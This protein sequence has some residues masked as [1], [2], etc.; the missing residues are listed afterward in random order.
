MRCSWN[1]F[2]N[3]SKVVGS[4]LVPSICITSSAK[5]TSLFFET[6]VK[7]LHMFYQMKKIVNVDEIHLIMIQ[8]SWVRILFHPSVLQVVQNQLNY[9]LRQALNV[10]ALSTS[11]VSSHDVTLIMIQRLWVRICS[12]HL[13]YIVQNQ[14]N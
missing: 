11:Y 13:Y 3:D 10:F 14:L 8:R 5:S 9:F 4:N 2:V 12:I 1:P 6:G 7:C